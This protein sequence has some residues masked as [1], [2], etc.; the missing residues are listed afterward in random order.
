MPDSSISV[1]HGVEAL[2]VAQGPLFVVVGVFDGLHRGHL[3]LLRPLRREARI[4]GARTTVITFDHHPDEV[5]TGHAPP[6]LCDPG[7][8]LVRLA[9][10]G[11]DVVVV[12]HFDE[13]LRHTPYDAFVERIRA[14]VALAGFL[15]TPDAAF[16]YE[17]RGTPA[18]LAELGARDGFDVV[19]IPP[20]ELD[21]RPVRSSEI[22]ALIAAG[23]L[24]TA[25][26]LLGRSVAVTAIREPRPDGGSH[27]RL[28]VPFALPPSGRYD[29]TVEPWLGL[30]GDGRGWRRRRVVEVRDGIVAVG[31]EF[32]ADP[33]ESVRV[34]LHRWRPVRLP[35]RG[36]P[37]TIR[38]FEQL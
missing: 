18:A 34:S 11:V 19:V 16:G 24:A 22:R 26:R 9:A 23:D 27:L 5:I 20:F 7:E 31:G 28:P 32:P 35:H 29:G 10:A 15:M 4:R 12:Q 30:E 25:R 36:D 38:P 21:G 17:R 3:Y 37:V 14:R 33:G 13:A 2:T 8:R 6:L 1:V